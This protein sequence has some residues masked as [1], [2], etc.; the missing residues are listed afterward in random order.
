[1]KRFYAQA[2]TGEAEGGWRVLLDGRP[3]RTVGGRPQVVPSRALA[4][5]MAAEWAGQ[6]EQI[7]PKSLLLR[8]LADFAI[9]VVAGDRAAIVAQLVRYAGTDTLCYRAEPD[10]RLH[11]RQ[12]EI[13]EP[14]LADAERRW[15]VHF[16]RINGIMHRSQP[17]GTL[18]RMARLLEAEDSFSLAALH[19]LTSLAASLVI[20]LAAIAPGADATALWAAANLEED[21][22][23]ELWG[24]D[25]EAEARRQA[26]FEAFAAAMRFAA[27]ARAR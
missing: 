21:W 4:E 2:T 16:E 22:Q 15:D 26:R 24:R 19:M 11:A 5:A 27:L 18:A 1:M 8:D 6:G 14:L 12:L 9:D 23:A 10:E 13:W 17:E 25:D 7:D 3:I 20:G